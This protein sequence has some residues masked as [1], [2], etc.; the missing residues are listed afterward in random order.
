MTNAFAE[1]SDA[2]DAMAIG[3]TLDS[4]FSGGAEAAQNMVQA[5][6]HAAEQMIADGSTWDQASQAIEDATDFQLVPI[7]G[8]MSADGTLLIQMLMVN[9]KHQQMVSIQ[10]ILGANRAQLEVIVDKVKLQYIKL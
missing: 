7:T 6:Q 4:T 10:L 5:M 9:N 2:I 8:N 1:S 3:D